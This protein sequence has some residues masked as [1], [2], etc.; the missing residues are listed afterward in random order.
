MKRKK[1]EGYISFQR[2]R[3]LL[4]HMIYLTDSN[5]FGAHCLSANELSM[6]MKKVK[7]EF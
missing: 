4:K 1:I 3:F 2:L 6:I 5:G 7:K